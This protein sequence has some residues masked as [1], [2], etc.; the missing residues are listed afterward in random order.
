MEADN[1]TVVLFVAA[2]LAY[3]II[4]A[5]CSSP[6]TAEINAHARAST[7]MKWVYIGLAQVVLFAILGAIIE[8]QRGKPVWPPLAGATLG[9]GLM[10]GQ[11]LYAKRAGLSSSEPGTETTPAPA[12]VPR[13]AFDRNDY[14]PGFGL[15]A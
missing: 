9:G 3:D 2:A 11:Y 8:K 4:A 15:A 7:L 6:Q 14:Y 10:L 1:P 5:A 12:P 13:P